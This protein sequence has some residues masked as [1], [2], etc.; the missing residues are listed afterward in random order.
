M[1]EERKEELSQEAARFVR[2]VTKA[3]RAPQGPVGSLEQAL[4]GLLDEEIGGAPD[5]ESFWD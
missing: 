1:S 4:Q 5:L 2:A 3:D